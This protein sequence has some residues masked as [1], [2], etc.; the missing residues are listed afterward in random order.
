MTLDQTTAIAMLHRRLGFGATADEL[1]ASVSAGYTATVTS[2]L[3]GLTQP[4]PGGDAIAVP[5]FSPP[6]V[7]LAQLRTNL[8]AR[9]AYFEQLRTE[10]RQLVVWWLARMVASSTPAHEK[11]TF[12][13]HGHFPT[14]ISKVHYPQFMYRQNQLFRTMGSGRLR[15]PHPGGRRRPGH[16]HLAGR[17]DGPGERPQRELRPRAHGALHHGHRELHRGRRARR[18]L[19]PSPAGSSI[20]GPGSSPSRPSTTRTPPQTFL[21]QS[22]VTS[23]QQVIEIATSTPA[24]ARYVPSAFWSHLASPV[25][26]TSSVAKDL[27][28]GY[29]A[30][31][32][33]GHPP[34]ERSS[35]TRTSP[36][37]RP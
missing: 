35:S 2:L 3:A 9:Q 10:A 26:P 31:R 33:V 21:G 13:L 22:G 5:T 4:D 20:C 25:T 16:A 27:A 15:H 12:L 23:G 7:P 32:S 19:L 1:S 28:P 34:A 36:P 8:A 18:R 14:A 17:G 6:P 29:A 30:D 11:L 24:S 37:R